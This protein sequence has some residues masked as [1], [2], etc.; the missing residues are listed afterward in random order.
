MV[1]VYEVHESRVDFW[2]FV[3]VER[4]WEGG[5]FLEGE[6]FV[7]ENSEGSDVLVRLVMGV[8][9]GKWKGVVY[10]SVT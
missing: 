4:C 5:C 6:G 7:A 3:L 10:L 1:G 8:F 9:R 2:C